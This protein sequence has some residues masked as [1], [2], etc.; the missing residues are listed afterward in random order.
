M[1]AFSE[2]KF[3]VSKLM[4]ILLIG[5]FGFLLGN[6]YADDKYL[7]PWLINYD[8]VERHVFIKEKGERNNRRFST[9]EFYSGNIFFDLNTQKKTL[10]RSGNKIVQMSH[11]N[12]FQWD[13]TDPTIRYSS[14]FGMYGPKFIPVFQQYHSM[15]KQNNFNHYLSMG[16]KTSEIP[17]LHYQSSGLGVDKVELRYDKLY[18]EDMLIPLLRK[19]LWDKKK[20][21]EMNLLGNLSNP[22]GSFRVQYAQAKVMDRHFPIKEFGDNHVVLIQI[23]RDDGRLASYWFSREGNHR[24]IKAILLDGSVLTLID[25]KRIKK[26]K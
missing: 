3:Q 6:T 9:V 2:S 24:L 21:F 19:M 18:S 5:F 23:I 10:L 8:D 20:E 14:E 17:I 15:D 7:A 16:Y 22:P 12:W 1:R 4:R 13:Q 11:F 25:Y 26:S